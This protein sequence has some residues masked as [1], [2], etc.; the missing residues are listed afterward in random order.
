MKF[1]QELQLNQKGS[2][3]LIKNSQTTKEKLYHIAVYLFKIAIT[4]AFCFLFVT[5]FSILFGSEN[6]IAGVVVLL[7]IM[8]FRQADFEIHAGQ[9]TVLLALFFINMTLC[10]HLANNFLRSQECW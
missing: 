9:S 5:L 1:Y 6:S 10:S 2:K 7:C 8:V 4:V 3:E